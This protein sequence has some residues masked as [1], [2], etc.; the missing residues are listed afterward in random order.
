MCVV[1]T[2]ATQDSKDNT[3]AQFWSLTVEQ[4]QKF[5]KEEHKSRRV[6]LKGTVICLVHTHK[7]TSVIFFGKGRGEAAFRAEK[8]IPRNQRMGLR[9]PAT[10][11][12]APLMLN[13]LS[14]YP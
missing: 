7:A 14:I 5:R 9:R 4:L 3:S 12:L 2:S 1:F 8:E 10:N 6:K 11:P 13:F